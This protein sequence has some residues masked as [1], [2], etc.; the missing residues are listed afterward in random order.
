VF[1]AKLISELKIGKVEAESGSKAS[2][3]LKVCD[4]PGYVLQLPVLIIN[5]IKDGPVLC[6]TGGVH[7]CEYCGT[8][9]IMRL[10]NSIDPRRIFGAI[11]AIPVVNTLAFQLRTPYNNPL[12]G[13][14]QNRVFPGDPEGTV[15]YVIADVLFREVIKKSNYLI[16][17][18]GGDLP[19]ENIDFVIVSRTGNQNVDKVSEAMGRCFNTEYEWLKG[20]SEAGLK[21]EGDLCGTANRNGIPGVIPEAGH[22]GKVQEASVNLLMNGALNV[23][24]YLKM[25]DGS[26][27][28][29]NPK[30]IKAQHLVKVHN[31]GFFHLSSQIGALVSKNEVLGE[32]RNLFGEVI[33]QLKSPVNGVLD[34]LMFNA[35]VLPGNTVMIIGEL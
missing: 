14:N 24:K 6:M 21:I 20:D 4:M 30:F 5:G 32:V 34:F 23:M 1:L 26:P 33:E 11:V 17:F 2:G 15:S 35:S 13:Q 16:E 7:A 9:T 27:S 28:L 22:S 25:Q 3:Y 29:G 19:E 10:F 18:H 31:S 8:E 12:D